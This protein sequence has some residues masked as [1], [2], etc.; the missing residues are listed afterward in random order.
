MKYLKVED[1]CVSYP[2]NGVAE[3]LVL[4]NI[5]F[6]LKN[7]EFIAV[8]GLSG[9]GKTT[10]LHSIMGLLKPQR[11]RLLVGK[12]KGN[13]AK[14]SVV[15]QDPL[16]LPW[17][18]VVQNISFGLEISGYPKGKIPNKVQPLIDLVKLSGYEA[19]YP[20]ALSGGMKQRTNLAR[21]LAVDP[22]ILLLDEPFSH[23][24]ALTREHMQMEILEIFGKTKK[25]F[26]FV[27]HLIDEAVFLADKVIVL[28]GKPARIKKIVEIHFKRPR[29]LSL[30]GAK[31]FTLLKKKLHNLLENETV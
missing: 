26:I 27:T 7:S 17:R 15:F 23:L 11:G 5:N 20:D 10:L 3:K 4:K 9:V 21:A 6:S 18:N 13:P 1:L 12:V 30:K 8:I 14:I 22:D 28:G 24:D 25:S 19:Y 29:N 31:A 2:N 16:L